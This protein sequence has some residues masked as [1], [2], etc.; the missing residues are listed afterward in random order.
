VTHVC[1]L[2]RPLQCALYHVNAQHLRCVNVNGRISNVSDHDAS[3]CLLW[4]RFGFLSPSVLLI[5]NCACGAESLELQDRTTTG[6][7]L[8]GRANASVEDY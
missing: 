5:V 8:Q 7:M 3:G 2:A 6:Q 4:V 1:L